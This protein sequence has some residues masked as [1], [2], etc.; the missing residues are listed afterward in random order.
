MH[1]HKKNITVRV[2]YCLVH[3]NIFCVTCSPFAFR[4]I[5]TPCLRSGISRILLSTPHSVPGYHCSL[6]F[7]DIADIALYFA[8]LAPHLRSGISSLPVCVRGYRGCRSAHHIHIPF[9]DILPLSHS[10]LGYLTSVQNMESKARTSVGD[11]GSCVGC[12][13]L[14]C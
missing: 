5:I 8:S 7:G 6:A 14:D 1:Q 12:G 10:V 4:D 11:A 3:H 9:S 2:S 13:D